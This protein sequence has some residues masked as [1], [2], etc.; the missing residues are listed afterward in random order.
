MSPACAACSTHAL[1]ARNNLFIDLKVKPEK[2]ESERRKEYRIRGRTG[3]GE[4]SGTPA[5]IRLACWGTRRK[6][7]MNIEDPP[8]TFLHR[9]FIQIHHFLSLNH[10]SITVLFL[11][12][13]CHKNFDFSPVKLSKFWITFVMDLVGKKTEDPRNLKNKTERNFNVL[14]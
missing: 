1:C 6:I 11:L 3:V 12:W 13:F 8:L 5:A 2:N 7:E 4:I 9:I 10:F 14:L